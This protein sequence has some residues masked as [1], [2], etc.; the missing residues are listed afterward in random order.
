MEDRE[1]VELY[2]ARAEKAIACT[3]EKYGTYCHAI[4]HHILQSD[5]DAEECVSDTYFRAWNTIPPQDPPCLRLFLGKITR[6]LAFHAFEKR[7]AQK[8]G[9]GEMPLVLEEL[10]ECIPAEATTESAVELRA[11]TA[12]LDRFADSLPSKEKQVFLRRYWYAYSI[13]AIAR[14]L[15][16]TENHVKVMLHRTRKKLKIQLQKEGVTV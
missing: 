10:S 8:R 1:I 12:V 5:E 3:A 14:Q 4:A 2:Q 7:R 9:G 15:N 13:Q 6:N 11:L 16:I